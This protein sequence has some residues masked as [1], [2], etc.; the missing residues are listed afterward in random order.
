M[1]IGFDGSRAFTKNRTGTE[2][3]S[4]QLLKHLSYIDHVNTYYV[5]L[6]PGTNISEKWPENFVF[7]VLN[8]KYLWTQVGLS[9]QT[10]KDPL[11][12]LFTPA[13]TTPLITKPGLKTLITVHD[14][15]AEYLPQTHQLKQRLY[16]NLMTHYQL[17]KATHLIA[18]SE[19]TKLDLTRKIGIKPSKVSVTYEGFNNENFKVLPKEQVS[20]K[21]REFDIEY[22]KYFFF[23]GSI[24]PRKNL[25]RLIRAYHQ[26]IHN[27]DFVSKNS[28]DLPKLVLAGGKG[29]LADEIYALP[30][31]LN[32]KDKVI[33]LGY[34]KDSDLP[35]LYNGAIALLFPSLFEGFGLPVLEAFACCCPVL[36]SDSSS[37]PE[38]AGDGAIL[39]DPRSIDSISKGIV[40]ITN[41]N[42]RKDL[43]KKG[44]RQLKKFSWDRCARETLDVISS[45]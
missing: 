16:L 10:F 24:Q 11:D 5:Y 29:W 14:L 17:K 38:V 43:T 42:N 40:T 25:E 36:T 23:V 21:L 37:L 18:V 30:T 15:G 8:Y 27:G 22:R 44:L 45:L 19:S 4:Y 28:K 26:A 1:V 41:E 35:Y 39:V 34:V 20:N 32:I 9:L 6:R 3:Y 2:N 12:L 31:K 33:F 7:K 13:H